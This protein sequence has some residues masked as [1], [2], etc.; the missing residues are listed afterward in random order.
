MPLVQLVRG[1]LA[2]KISLLRTHP[3][4]VAPFS[5]QWPRSSSP[6]G[7]SNTDR[8]GFEH[9]ADSV[10]LSTATSQARKGLLLD[11]KAPR[12]AEGGVLMGK[13]HI[14][15]DVDVSHDQIEYLNYLDCHE[16]W[17]L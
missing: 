5:L 10:E 17:G 2:S 6:K 14:R 11:D 7:A 9:L 12:L 13:V 4:T 15:N 3:R 8:D 1:N 16:I